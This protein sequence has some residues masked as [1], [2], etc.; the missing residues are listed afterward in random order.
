MTAIEGDAPQR[1]AVQVWDS[2]EKV[3]AYRNDPKFKELRAIGEKYAKFRTFVI[4]G[5]AQ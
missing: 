4:E 2:L 1:A 5:L 3:E